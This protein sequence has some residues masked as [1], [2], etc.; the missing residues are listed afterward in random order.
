VEAVSGSNVPFSEDAGMPAGSA[1]AKRATLAADV[2]LFADGT[3]LVREPL[4]FELYKAG[5]EQL[6]V[7]A[8]LPRR[9]LCIFREEHLQLA[10]AL[11][12]EIIESV[13]IAIEW[14]PNKEKVH[15]CVFFIFE[16]KRRY[17]GGDQFR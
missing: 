17:F 6:V 15:G 16:F 11:T 7:T 5:V 13:Y 2:K 12:I 8:A 14:A 4:A 10:L 9:P 3:L 1:R